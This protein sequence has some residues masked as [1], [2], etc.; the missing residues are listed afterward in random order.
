MRNDRYKPSSMSSNP[1]EYSGISSN[2]RIS[3]YSSGAGT[4]NSVNSIHSHSFMKNLAANKPPLYNNNNQA[5][6]INSGNNLR[7]KEPQQMDD[8]SNMRSRIE[9]QS[10]HR[11]SRLSPL[12]RPYND[13][14]SPSVISH[15]NTTINDEVRNKI[16]V[17]GETERLLMK[18]NEIV[19]RNREK[20]IEYVKGLEDRLQRMNDMKEREVTEL[21]EVETLG[22][23]ELNFR[24][25][26]SKY[27]EWVG[28]MRKKVE[29]REMIY[30]S[31]Y[32]QEKNG[33]QLDAFIRRK[34]GEIDNDNE[35]EEDVLKKKVEVLRYEERDLKREIDGLE[36]ELKQREG[37]WVVSNH[38]MMVEA[39]KTGR[40][41]MNE[42]SY[43]V[44]VKY[45]D[46]YMGERN[47]DEAGRQI[48][49]LLGQR[50]HYKRQCEEEEL[51]HDENALRNE[52]KRM[53]DYLAAR[54]NDGYMKLY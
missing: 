2:N 10:S 3:G 24:D 29:D 8:S 41:E 33:R 20:F 9:S 7:F 51:I 5:S 44:V 4:Q 43:G 40:R 21:L 22:L 15:M 30:R 17:D 26:E 36:R 49:S 53:E 50:D 31:I 11:Q 45:F 13:S 38:R 42:M 14:K 37:E 27:R 28:E 46:K 48:K 19:D 32:K 34:G 18:Y 35:R 6:P 54:K 47:F 1:L 12:N 23:S 39:E 52:I 25:K 16:R